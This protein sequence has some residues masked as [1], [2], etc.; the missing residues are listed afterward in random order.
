MLWQQL[1]QIASLPNQESLHSSWNKP[2]NTKSGKLPTYHPHVTQAA[3]L[4]AWTIAP[5]HTISSATNCKSTQWMCFMPATPLLSYSTAVFLQYSF[6]A[7]LSQAGFPSMPV[8][9]SLQTNGKLK[10]CKN[11]LFHMLPYL[12]QTFSSNNPRFK[13]LAAILPSTSSKAH[14]K[15]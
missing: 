9:K 5:S 10:S 14:C 8:H 2:K 3:P 7:L 1:E 12:P 6:W 15:F 4:S 11:A 13:T